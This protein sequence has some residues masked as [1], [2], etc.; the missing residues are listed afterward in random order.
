[1]LRW[2]KLG[3][4]FDPREHDLPDG[5][6]EYAQYPHPLVFQDF[7]RIYFSA[8]RR[9]PRDGDRWFSHVCF[10]DMD[11]ALRTVLRVS[12]QTVIE[13]GR[14]GCFDEHGIF[15]M[16]V[17]RSGSRIYGYTCG[18]SRRASVAADC[19]I[20]FTVSDDDGVTFQRLGNGPILT[21]SLHEPFLVADPYVKQFE[22][23]FH[24]WY[25]YGIEWK[26]YAPE[27]PPDRIYKIGH[28]VSEDG[29]SWQ[30]EGRQ[31]LEDRFPEESQANPAVI[32][33]DGKYH[34]LFCYRQ[35]FDFRTNRERSYRIGYAHSDDLVNW[36]RDDA[37]VGI[38]VTEGTWDSDMLC[39]PDVF[40]VDGQI[41]LLYNG[42]EFGRHGFGLARLTRV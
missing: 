19:S 36:I 29:I 8:R 10:V 18:I 23:R 12:S 16:Y 7:V 11:K 41:Y 25:V 38:D 28:A 1:M 20:G 30:K 17:L 3:R 2:E 34:M 15:P 5:C 6:T 42:N 31:L 40:E 21:A 37:S 4:I 39:Y 35:S 24:M 9:D 32:C 33:F 14:L 22:D 27:A 13:L 26:Q